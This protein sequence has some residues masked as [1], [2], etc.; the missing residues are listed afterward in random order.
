VAAAVDLQP[1]IADVAERIVTRERK[2]LEHL[3]AKFRTPAE[4]R[5]YVAKWYEGH[6]EFV[7]RAMGPLVAAYGRVGW[8]VAAWADSYCVAAMNELDGRP[9]AEV[10]ELWLT[11]KAGKLAADIKERLT[12]TTES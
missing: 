5:Q 12:C 7:A 2:S 8:H 1:V 10:M 4:K 3:D 6:S 11:T 9:V